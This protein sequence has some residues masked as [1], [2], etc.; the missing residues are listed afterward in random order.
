MKK[1]LSFYNFKGGSGKTALNILSSLELA[2]RGFRVLLV[3]A[4]GQANTTSF[5]Y[6]TDGTEKTIID[7]LIHNYKME[8]TII[9]SPLEQYPT[10]DLIPASD[11]IRDLEYLIATKTA[12]EKVF[13]RWFSKNIETAKE[14][15][16][17]IFDLS[18]TPGLINQNILIALDS[19]ITIIEFDDVSSLRGA[20]DFL[21]K[22]KDDIEILELPEAKIACTI[23]KLEDTKSNSKDI[24]NNYIELYEDIN[25]IM[26]DSKIH[27][28]V[29]IKTSIL[30]RESLHDYASK[31]KSKTNLRSDEEL[32][33][34]IDELIR[35]E[36]L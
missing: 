8:D 9:K 21:V 4:D 30:Y 7:A 3:D 17:I 18:P 32:K 20:D 28:S 34:L 12:K 36:M 5:L 1:C 16:Y 29:A 35:K 24:F 22:Y 31:N 10:L 26:L 15:D 13:L 33:G 14:Y 11:N 6:D 23:N 25:N 19:I 27:R 2:R